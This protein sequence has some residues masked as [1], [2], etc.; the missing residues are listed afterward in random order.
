[1]NL[2]QL[3]LT[4]TAGAIAGAAAHAADISNTATQYLILKPKKPIVI[5]GKLGEWDMASTP[6]TISAD[7]KNPMNDVHQNEPSNPVKGDSDLSGRA[8]LAWDEQ[9]LYIAGQMVDDHLLGVKP[10]SAG[11]QGPAG[12]GCDSLMVSVASCHQP[13][14]SNSPFSRT[15]FLGLR[16]AP[17]GPSARGKLLEGP[18]G[19]LDKKDF[20]W[21]L[22]ANSKW[23]VTETDN[24]YNVEAAVPWKDLEFTARPGERLFISFLAAD[25]DP[26][27]ALNQL[28]W[29]FSGQ[30]NENPIFRLADREDV[31]GMLTVSSDS[32]AT[33]APWQVRAEIDALQGDAKL[34]AIRV[35]DERGKAAFEAKVGLD[36]PKGKTGSLLQEFKAGA[37]ATPGRYTIEETATA[38]GKRVEVVAQLPVQ[39]VAQIAE[40]PLIGNLPGETHHMGP[41][42]VAHNALQRPYRHGF[43][44]GTNDYVAFIR[45]QVE[46]GLKGAAQA[47]I[48]SKSQW[49]YPHAFHCMALYRLTGDPEYAQLARDIM[50]Y[51]LDAGDLGWFKLTAVAQ[52][53]YLTWK[54]DPSSPFAPKDAE[55]RYRANLCKVA[56]KPD[57]SLFNESGTHNR[58]WH[59]YA[60]QKIARMV[61]E[62]DG[63]PVDPRIKEYT[64]YH[65]KIIGDVGDSDD[66]SAGYHWVFFD[67]AV[68]IYFHTGNWDAFLKNRGYQK[69]LARYVEMVSPSGACAPFSSCSGWPEVGESMWAYELMST[70]TRDGRYRWTSHRIAEYYYNH[71]DPFANQYHLPFDTARNG[72][73]MAFLLADDTVAPKE[74]PQASRVTWRHPL[75]KV[76]PEELRA[77]PGTSPMK[78]ADGQWI[79]DKAVL[80]SGTSALGLWGMV[81]LL[82]VAGHGG[83]LPG[84]IVTLMANDSALFA[85]QGYYENTPDFQNLLWVEDLDGV[86]PDPRPMT[87]DV[88]VF[89]ED[90]AFTFVRVRTTAYQHLPLTY[91][92]DILFCKNGFMVVKDRAEFDATM[93]VRL[94]P[95]YYAR[96]LGPQ[97]GTNWFNAYYDELYYTG[98]GLGRGVQAIQN[99]PWD[100]MIYYVPRVDYRQTV[101]DRFLDNR[102]RNSPV[103]IRQAWTGMARAGSE[104]TFTSVLLP[105]APTFTPADLVSPPDTNSAPWIEVAKDDADL[106]VMKV[107]SEHSPGTRSDAWVMLNDT[108]KPAEAGPLATDAR[109][110]VVAVG[111]DGKIRQRAIVGG[112]AL[113]F[114]GNDEAPS[115]RRLNVTPLAVPAEFR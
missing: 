21:V 113:K 64:D 29:G 106:T 88:P 84:N 74:P 30:P 71:L 102:Y 100:L 49:G 85:G 62:E 19:T 61:A 83:E 76:S 107:T 103:Q 6:Y 98:L 26:D 50:D 108:G 32:V 14:K 55:K 43:V 60:L 24:G 105:H 89:I 104:F 48:K 36:V 8:A 69:T 54:K 7:G 1:M 81:E 35:L 42:R 63:Q 39:V 112:T 3:A 9:Y 56:A 110:A 57:L 75:A 67:A 66:A 72:F 10:D 47:D 82:P 80:S 25:I 115:A 4:L 79:P 16:Y 45:K 92:R 22:T 114:R 11:N 2:Q 99:P 101:V 109:V 94:G 97:C 77:R 41:N 111:P 13:M 52:Y 90:P 51:T 31:L 53:R 20:Y 70:L 27:E 46:P 33:N 40:A 68:G 15:P 91:T 38:P 23:A 96:D 18:P 93:K 44:K 59:R 34:D 87:T 58:V 65:D 95:C 17:T 37:I 12:W 28:G 5:D 86:A 73:V 78:M